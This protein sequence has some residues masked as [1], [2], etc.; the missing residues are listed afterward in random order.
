MPHRKRKSARDAKYLAGSMSFFGRIQRSH[1]EDGMTIVDEIRLDAI[2]VEG[3]PLPKSGRLIF[4]PG[5][6]GEPV[7]VQ[8]PIDTAGRQE[9]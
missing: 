3:V 4:D 2:T 7:E 9:P 6:T 5:E 8:L 1:E